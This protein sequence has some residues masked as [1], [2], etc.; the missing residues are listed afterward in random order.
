MASNRKQNSANNYHFSFFPPVAGLP[1]G[2]YLM[3]PA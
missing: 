1:A 3:L 2:I